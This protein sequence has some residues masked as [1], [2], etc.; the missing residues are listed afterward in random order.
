MGHADER[1]STTPPPAW[2]E[3]AVDELKSGSRQ[4]AGLIV[5]TNARR[6]ASVT[7]IDPSKRTDFPTAFSERATLTQLLT[8][9]R[10]TVHAK[11]V[12]LSQSDAVQTPL[13]SSP[14]MSIA[15][16]VSHLRWS[17]AFWIDVVFLGRP[18]QW[19]G[20]DHDSEL[21]MRRGLEQPLA[22]LL[23]EYAK[24]A[25]HT[26]N[27]IAARDWDAE[28]VGRD[29]NTGRAFALRY[30]ITHLIAETARHN[31]HLDI[32]RE[33]ADGVTGD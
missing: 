24:Q 21:Q 2:W 19:P 25:A 23:D 26:D 1:A 6:G 16:L 17:E 32:L 12:G 28:A 18:N 29:E 8:Y 31:G 4:A 13:E 15:G 10:L 14:S 30:I 27:I 11:C 9:V 3:P 7:F 22:E 33:L 5:T 20:T